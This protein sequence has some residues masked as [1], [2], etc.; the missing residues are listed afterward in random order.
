MNTELSELRH[1]NEW[2]TVIDLV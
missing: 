2:A 1:V